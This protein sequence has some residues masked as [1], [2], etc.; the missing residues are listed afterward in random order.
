MT[1]SS[2]WSLIVMLGLIFDVIPKRSIF[3]I[4]GAV[5]SINLAWLATLCCMSADVTDCF[6]QFSFYR[7]L[8]FNVFLVTLDIRP[9]LGESTLI[10]CWP[11]SGISL[12]IFGLLNYS[13]VSGYCERRLENENYPNSGYYDRTLYLSLMLGDFLFILNNILILIII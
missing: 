5:F 2:S 12:V 4:G 8:V 11:F 13:F 6:L 10:L 1:S 9:W 7:R 3:G